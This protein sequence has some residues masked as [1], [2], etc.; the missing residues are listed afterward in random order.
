MTHWKVKRYSVKESNGRSDTNRLLN[1]S[2]T[3]RGGPAAGHAQGCCRRR[4]SRYRPRDVS[5]VPA[6][7]T[8]IFPRNFL[9]TIQY[10][11]RV[12]AAHSASMTVSRIRGDEGSGRSHERRAPG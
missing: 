2:D 9:H 7:S 10:E 12:A 5:S 6:L 4:G 11:C 8:V 3:D 1:K